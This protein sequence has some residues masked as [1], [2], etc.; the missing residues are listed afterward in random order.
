MKILAKGKNSEKIM[1]ILTQDVRQ[2]VV[3][4]ALNAQGVPT[5]VVGGTFRAR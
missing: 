1:E 5:V 4:G 2:G 3:F